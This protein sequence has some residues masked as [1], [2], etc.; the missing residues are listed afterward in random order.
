MRFP[1]QKSSSDGHIHALG[2][3]GDTTLAWDAKNETDVEN[4][5]RMF[6]ELRGK[7]Y[8]AFTSGRSRKEMTEFDP[9]ARKMVM[10]PPMA[11]GAVEEQGEAPTF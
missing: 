1:T 5:R 6:D 4:A 2:G 8:K 3:S 11:A 10:V 9:T 7:G